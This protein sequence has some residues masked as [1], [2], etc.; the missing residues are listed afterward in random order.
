MYVISFKC[1][2][3]CIYVVIPGHERDS[4]DPYSIDLVGR[5]LYFLN[6]IILPL[7]RGVLFNESNMKLFLSAIKAK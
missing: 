4:L 5:R 6:E 1:M 7:V 2:L 3:L